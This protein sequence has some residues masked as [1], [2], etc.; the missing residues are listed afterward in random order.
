MSFAN[1]FCGSRAQGTHDP[2]LSLHAHLVLVSGKA[3][4]LQCEYET[5]HGRLICKVL[6]PYGEDLG[7][8]QLKA[9]IAWH[10]KQYQDQQ[11]SADGEA[12]DGLTATLPGGCSL[13]RNTVRYGA[14]LPALNWQL[15][16]PN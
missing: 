10:Y 3:V 4:T 5:S 7:L 14:R 8:D 15:R 12:Y 11:S 13:P 16:R 1:R 9:G 6:L 2:A